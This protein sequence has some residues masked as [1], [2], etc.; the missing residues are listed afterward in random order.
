MDA[1]GRSDSA[2]L[3]LAARSARTGGEAAPLRELPVGPADR[4]PRGERLALGLLAALLVA[5]AIGFG[6]ERS[7]NARLEAQVGELGGELAAARAALAAHEA[8]LEEVRGA[9]ARLHALVQ[10]D[11][12]APPAVSAPPER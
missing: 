12:L 11:P 2:R 8:R 6:V 7:R 5:C 3:R 10:A 1:G 9:V 4:A